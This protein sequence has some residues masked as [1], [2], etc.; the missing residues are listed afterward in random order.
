MGLGGG[1]A[2]RLM[3]IIGNTETVIKVVKT[4]LYCSRSHL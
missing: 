3:A 1:Y 4:D 2:G